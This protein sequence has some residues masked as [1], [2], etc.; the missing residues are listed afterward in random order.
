M[1]KRI[2]WI[3]ITRGI[4][5]ILVIYGHLFSTDQQR[6]LIYAFHMP[7]FFFISGMVFTPLMSK[8][9]LFIT[10]KYFKQLLIPYYIFAVMTYLFALISQTADFSLS[11][12]GYQLFGILYGSGRDGMLGYN[13][14]LWFLPCLFITKL[15][16]AAITRRVS[17]TGKLLLIL[18]VSALLGSLLSL[19]V[20]WLKLPLGFE[21]ALTALPFFGMGYLFKIHENFLATFIRYKL[22]IAAVAMT[23]LVIVASADF[24]LSGHQIDMRVNQ[25][26]VTPLFYLGAFSGI[27]GWTAISQLIARNTLLEYI[28]KH[29]LIIFA[30]H[31]ILLIDLRQIVNSLLTQN[32]LTE[33]QPFMAT[34]YMGM[35]IGII[36]VSRKLVVKLKVAYRFVPF[37]KQ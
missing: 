9:L 1:V 23:I 8:S 34:V 28:G 6:Y 30:W 36:L 21:I 10:L 11:G 33:I 4:G 3:D 19:L 18:C 17:H 25:L 35:A 12:M 13:V 24:S 22:P 27:I 16:F 20:P 5:I 31:N 29:S 15:L 32:I 7:L 37:L 14:V 26:D 2:H